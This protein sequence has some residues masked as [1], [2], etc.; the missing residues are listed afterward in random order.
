[1]NGTRAHDSAST[2]MSG[3]TLV[4]SS[5]DSGR[6]RGAEG[7]GPGSGGSARENPVAIS[8]VSYAVAIYPYMAELEDEFDV[9]V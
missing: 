2:A 7:D 4:G 9:V 1:M 5:A 3:A 6:Y 8:G